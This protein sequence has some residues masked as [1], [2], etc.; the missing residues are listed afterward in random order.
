MWNGFSGPTHA[1]NKHARGEWIQRTGM[2]NFDFHPVTALEGIA[3]FGN[4]VKRGPPQGLVH[5]ENPA[6]LKRFYIRGYV[7]AKTV[8]AAATVPSTRQ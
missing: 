5:R 3:H 4:Y 1:K 8:H 2:A 7:H 6:C